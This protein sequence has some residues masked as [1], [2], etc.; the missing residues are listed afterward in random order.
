MSQS[1]RIPR[2]LWAGAA[3]TA[4]A[5]VA[6]PG[7]SSTGETTSSAPTDSAKLVGATYLST[8]VNG[9]QIPGGGPLEVSFPE[10]GRMAA[11]A[12]CNRH[13]GAVTITDTTL[14][15]QALASTMMACPGDRGQADAWL[16]DFFSAPLTVSTPSPSALVLERGQGADR[17][18]VTLAR[19]ENKALVGPAWTV[20]NLVTAQA[21]ETSLALE[22]AKPTLTFAEGRVTGSTGCNTLTGPA[23][24]TGDRVQ[25]GDL[26]V[27]RRA[28]DEETARIEKVVLDTLRGGATFAIDGDLL[29]LTNVDDPSTG[30]RLRTQ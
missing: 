16:A 25:F 14:T 2:A 26:A 23:T 22:K 19:R 27:T 5:I 7:C 17:R 18:A 11:T 8:T 10:A 21:V 15:A 9:P 1:R 28:C 20:T 29:T 13:T 3:L 30:L 6:L 24:I 12:G 4:A